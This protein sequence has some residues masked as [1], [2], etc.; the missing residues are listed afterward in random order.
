M[1]VMSLINKMRQ[2]SYLFNQIRS[3]R[4]RFSPWE[5]FNILFGRQIIEQGLTSV[6]GVDGS[7]LPKAILRRESSLPFPELVVDG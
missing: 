5:D 3:S 4:S 2:A 6:A 7:Y 1:Q